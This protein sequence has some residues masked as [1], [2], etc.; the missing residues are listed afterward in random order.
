MAVNLSE[1]TYEE[2][3]KLRQKAIASHRFMV[4]GEI[5]EHLGIDSSLYEESSEEIKLWDLYVSEKMFL[6]DQLSSVGFSDPVLDVPAKTDDRLRYKIRDYNEARQIIDN[7]SRSE[8]YL[9][10]LVSKVTGNTGF[11]NNLDYRG[12]LHEGY[13]IRGIAKKIL[14]KRN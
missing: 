12:L 3:I 14:K 10:S 5:S 11:A 2:L 4:F 13:K 8:I 6:A 7:F 1:L 9:R